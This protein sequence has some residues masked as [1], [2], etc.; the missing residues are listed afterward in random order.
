MDASA[1]P[2]R[3]IRPLSMSPPSTYPTYARTIP[4]AVKKWDPHPFASSHDAYAAPS[5]IIRALRCHTLLR[6]LIG[7]ENGQWWTSHL[8]TC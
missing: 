6:C 3:G 7:R 4:P 8:K 2:H 5:A 1:S